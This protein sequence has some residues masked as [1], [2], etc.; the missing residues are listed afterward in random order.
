[1]TAKRFGCGWIFLALLG[2]SEDPNMD[3]D[4]AR[5]LYAKVKAEDFHGWDR[6]PGY[7]LRTK[8]NGPHGGQV[9]IYV[10]E[11]LSAAIAGPPITSWP[12]ASIIVKEGF[13]GDKLSVTAMM[14]KRSDGWYWAELDASGAPM[15]SGH[16]SV[17]TD[18]HGSGAD[19][20]RSFGFPK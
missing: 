4:G 2:C 16:P 6:P 20:V 9:D 13:D 5:A 7:E 12:K 1:M 10:N 19:L 11:V 17:C 18:C 15:A 8:S 3:P 14:E